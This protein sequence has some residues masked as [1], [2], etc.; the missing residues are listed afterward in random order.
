MR[1]DRS[2]A[3]ALGSLAD[4]ASGPS[5]WDSQGKASLTTMAR[6]PLLVLAQ[7]PWNCGARFSWLAAM[8]SCRSWVVKVIGWAS[9][10]HWSAVSRSA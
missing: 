2:A 6:G 4:E 1:I 9:A 7:W 10:S 8:P 5:A 3:L